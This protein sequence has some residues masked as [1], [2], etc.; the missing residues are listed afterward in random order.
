MRDPSRA[1]EDATR[2]PRAAP[3]RRGR[4]KGRTHPDLA[5]IEQLT[6]NAA[7]AKSLRTES[8]SRCLLQ[9]RAGD[10]FLALLRI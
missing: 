9:C 2:R 1:T 7:H 8:P 10:R 4:A 6:P 5:R 3:G